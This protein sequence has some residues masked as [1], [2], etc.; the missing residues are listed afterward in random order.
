M[1]V[2]IQG[3]SLT[4]FSAD[5]AVDLWWHDCSSGRRVNQKGRK[6]YRTRKRNDL[7]DS[8]NSSEEESEPELS[9]DIWD[10]WFT[11]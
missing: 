4:N 9:L 6:D 2:N 5:S 11:D 7:S 3:P 10:N 8:A 1:E